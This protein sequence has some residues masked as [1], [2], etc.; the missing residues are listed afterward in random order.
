[1]SNQAG[2]AGAAQSSGVNPS[3]TTS[4]NPSPSGSTVGPGSGTGAGR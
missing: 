2:S 3:G 1:M 4:I